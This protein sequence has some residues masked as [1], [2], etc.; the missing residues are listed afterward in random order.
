MTGSRAWLAAALLAALIGGTLWI[1]G[2]TPTGTLWIELS[3]SG[4]AICLG[5]LVLL[6]GSLPGTLS[7]LPTTAFAIYLFLNLLRVWSGMTQQWY[8]SFSALLLLCS[9][10][11]LFLVSSVAG[12]DYDASHFFRLVLSVYGP[13]LA[14]FSLV[15]V[16]LTNGKIYWIYSPPQAPQLAFGPYVN[17]DH[18]AAVIELLFPFA[19]TVALAHKLQ[20]KIRSFAIVGC[21]AMLA[22]MIASRSRAGALILFIEVLAVLWTSQ[23]A[24]SAKWKLLT[25]VVACFALL[26]SMDAWHAS[27]S[28][29]NRFIYMQTSNGA[30]YS[31]VAIAKDS[32]RML[33]SKPWIGIGLGT[34]RHEFP[35][36]KTLPGSLAVTHAHNDYL[37]II[38]EGGILGALPWFIFLVCVVGSCWRGARQLRPDCLPYAIAIACF[39]LHSLVDFNLFVPGNAALFYALCGMLLAAEK[40]PRPATFFTRRVNPYAEQLT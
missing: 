2:Y 3:S 26:I 25:V 29:I 33:R 34:F 38:C 23:L 32:F 4:L 1:G 31:R 36:F 22:S 12:S 17:R 40:A 15:Q 8:L 6:R 7:W 21:A 9:Y 30:S 20:T 37:E 11:F 13:L 24:R 35:R 28:L 39:L 14:V 27:E 18:Y 16:A 10:F 19:A 5:L